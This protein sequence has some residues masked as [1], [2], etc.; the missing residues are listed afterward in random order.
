ML[1]S[2]TIFELLFLNPSQ[3]SIVSYPTFAIGLKYYFSF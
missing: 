2:N 1:L 3:T